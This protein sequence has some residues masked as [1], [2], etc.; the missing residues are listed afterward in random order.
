MLRLIPDFVRY[1][2][3]A[4]NHLISCAFKFMFFYFGGEA[5][6]TLHRGCAPGP[7]PPAA[8][9]PGSNYFLHD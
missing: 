5:P 9:A 7:P 3:T 4:K 2:L 1:F 8:P 6:R